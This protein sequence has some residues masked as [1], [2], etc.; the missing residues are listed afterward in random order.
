MMAKFQALDPKVDS[1]RILTVF[2]QPATDGGIRCELDVKSLASQPIYE[3]VSYAWSHG[4]AVKTIE[5]NGE[6]VAVNQHIYEL[7]RTF[8][9]RGRR[10]LWIDALC[11]NM[12]DTQ[13]RIDQVN[14]MSYVYSRAERVLA[15]LGNAKRSFSKT[16]LKTM[17]EGKYLPWDDQHCDAV[18]KSPYWKRRWT[19]QEIVLA[20]D[21][22]FH[23]GNGFFT[24]A[25]YYSTLAEGE[26][27]TRIRPHLRLIESI[28]K[29]RPSDLQRLEVLLETFK[30]LE[31]HDT[32]DKI[33]S[34]VG[35]ADDDAQA[36]IEVDYDKPYYDI[37]TQLVEY[38]QAA[39]PIRDWRAL[40]ARDH[41]FGPW[42][43]P[44][45]GWAEEIE[46]SLRLVSFSH[47]VQTTLGGLA[48]PEPDS[49]GDVD[50]RD[51]LFARGVCVGEI[52]H[53]G[54]GYDE[55]VAAWQ[56]NRRWKLTLDEVYDNYS[57]L[58]EL[59]KA[60]AKFAHTFLLW[61]ER[62][63]RAIQ[64][65]DTVT[66]YGFRKSADDESIIR[67]APADS[68]ATSQPRRFLGTNGLMGFLPPRAKVGDRIF[69][70]WNTY[71][72]FIVRQVAED[73]WMIVG[74]TTLAKEGME[75]IVNSSYMRA[76]HYGTERADYIV[77]KRTGEFGQKSEKQAAEAMMMFK[78]DME[79]LQ[80]LT[81]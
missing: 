55:F 69:S 28:R 80:M 33:F 50:E 7:L 31:C 26:A 42:D 43:D 41:D 52:L 62:D 68:I 70:F 6:K 9:K 47:L 59:R 8:R 35:L 61:D 34:L 45:F 74:R 29:S 49:K 40:Y 38:F 14:M 16:Q 72:G 53:I 12:Q 30:H 36:M 44:I 65:I 63:L 24:M 56:P 77:Y 23:L 2:G 21:I 27:L 64:D 48:H 39:A 66:S 37:Y 5:I 73:R 71:I 1:I 17:K 19:I 10:A 32:R 15:Y 79:T 81:A 75:K 57:N 18:A 25:T 78:L 60:D 11:I 13:E 51:P 22:Q 20:K 46:R 58:A 54:P 4:P 3:A 67:E 76:L